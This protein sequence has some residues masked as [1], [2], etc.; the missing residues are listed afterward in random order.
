VT[1][2][3]RKLKIYAQAVPGRVYV[4]QDGDAVDAEASA[5]FRFDHAFADG[6]LGAGRSGI[7]AKE[8]VEITRLASSY[9]NR[10][11]LSFVVR[12][13]N[14]LHDNAA[15]ATRIQPGDRISFEARRPAVLSPGSALASWHLNNAADTVVR[16][17]HGF[18]RS[19]S[20]RAGELAV[21]VLDPLERADDVMLV[22]DLING[23]EIPKLAINLPRQ[24]DDHHYSLKKTGASTFGTGQ[25][26]LVGFEMTLGE[27]L[28][29]LADLYETRLIN[30]GVLDTGPLFASADLADLTQKLGPVVL[31]NT[32]F[33]SG[34]LQLLRSAPDV[35]VVV[36]HRTKQWRIVPTAAALKPAASLLYQQYD[37]GPGDPFNTVLRLPLADA[38]LFSATPGADG[39]RIRIYDGDDPSKSEEATVYA[40]TTS[41]PVGGELELKLNETLSRY[42]SSVSLG[43]VRSLVA[44]VRAEAL[45]TLPVDVGAAD[46]DG[47]E[48]TLDLEGTYSAV[49][50]FS[51]NQE[52][53]VV[54]HYNS[55][56]DPAGSTLA[57][58]WNAAFEASWKQEDDDRE[59][60]FGDD[61]GGLR[62]YAITNDGTRDVAWVKYVRSKWGANHVHNEWQGVSL[63][64]W[65]KN[66]GTNC[67]DEALTFTVYGQTTVTD[68]GDGSPG[69][70]LVLDTAVGG[71]AA[72][73]GPFG[74][75]VA[76]VS[77][78]EDRAVLTQD[79]RFATTTAQNGRSGIGRDYYVT[80][81]THERDTSS[82][83]S[84]LTCSPVKA[85]V[86]D[87]SGQLRRFA[88]Q[89]PGLGY[90]PQN[91]NVV[92][93]WEQLAGGGIGAFHVFR[94]AVRFAGQTGHACPGGSGWAPPNNVVVEMERTTTSVRQARFPSS[95]FGGQALLRY[96]V[97][98]TLFLA[99]E[100]WTT[101]AE[102]A[103][104]LKIAERLWNVHQNA[105]HRGSVSFRGVDQWACLLDLGVRVALTTAEPAALSA[106]VAG[107]WGVLTGVDLDFA[108]DRVT[109]E[110]DSR[111]PN[112]D[113]SLDFLKAMLSPRVTRESELRALVEKARQR[114]ACLQGSLSNERPTTICA[115]RVTQP[116]RGR[117][118][119]G[120]LPPSAKDN[121]QHEI[122][123]TA[124]GVAE[125]G[126][127]ATGGGDS[128]GRYT[129]HG[130][131][132][133]ETVV[134]DLE[135]S[136]FVV[137][138][139][140]QIVPATES[141]KE[142]TKSTAAATTPV[143]L[144]M[145]TQREADAAL[146]ALGLFDMAH[147]A[148]LP[149]PFRLAA[150]STT[151]AIKVDEPKLPNEATGEGFVEITHYGVGSVRPR[152]LAASVTGGDTI[153]LAAAMSEAAPVA[154]IGAVFWPK[155][156]NRPNPA[157][158][159]AGSFGFKDSSGQWF[160]WTPTGTQNGTL[161]AATVNGTTKLLDKTTAG[162][163]APFVHQ[164]GF[165]AGNAQVTVT[166]EFH[167]AVDFSNAA[168][169]GLGAAWDFDEGD[170]AAAYAV[171][172][173]DLEGGD[174]T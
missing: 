99:T 64:A 55:L 132:A 161:F 142:A 163:A 22:R 101:D 39:W 69:L 168:V 149:I 125:A 56:A 135:G 43:F 46:A 137:G 7:E 19:V 14:A 102:Q 44:P 169:T 59:A 20:G 82:A 13:R 61:G 106:N 1:L 34:V 81:T 58:A 171:G 75:E 74:T 8:H 91:N 157:D 36:D 42:Y 77:A 89:D 155:G 164:D 166:R 118:L 51:E 92:N 113:L 57:R 37:G 94:R 67:R 172:T 136:V 120:A 24:H 5:G 76:P 140:G 152:Y 110:F 111:D 126:G 108:A 35:R 48:L 28:A 123:E 109:L 6:A 15:G 68:V 27:A 139:V 153:N 31:E 85:Y 154:G 72:A 52:T 143:G 174:A 119:P 147:E 103:D 21:E 114:L 117:P 129:T 17:M 25:S 26:L 93:G 127:A 53:E 100:M 16:L 66:G 98:R 79:Y 18:V 128:S 148:H 134:R 23:I 2:R 4:Y 133:S 121:Q 62:L 65:T 33:G 40:K 47:V 159:P 78:A 73:V 158:F 150:G 30:A 29:E 63:W 71:F 90:P 88:T 97:Q 49:Q 3:D 50:I 87:G 160:V 146:R 41:G 80:V 11:T 84:Q 151:T 45:P 141:G 32:G 173:L 107:F 170:A 83:L 165:E 60:D 167:G 104:Y 70:R 112:A 116:G 96:G 9:D 10:R 130:P 138:G 144:P 54:T 105:H 156:K 95:G 115:A 162:A 12:A 122:M 124:L 131:T 38:A 145:R 86:D